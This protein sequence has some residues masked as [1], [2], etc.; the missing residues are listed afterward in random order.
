MIVMTTFLKKY[1]QP[2]SMIINISETEK[3][4]LQSLC[5]DKGS[6]QRLMSKLVPPY[7]HMGRTSPRQ[8]V[9]LRMH[10]SGF[11]VWGGPGPKH[12]DPASNGNSLGVNSSTLKRGPSGIVCVNLEKTDPGYTNYSDPLLGAS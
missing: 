2:I 7:R 10:A 5:S 12:L 3:N 4:T 8:G 1:H 6:S 11:R 9:R